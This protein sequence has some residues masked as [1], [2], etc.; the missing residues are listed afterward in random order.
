MQDVKMKVGWK[1]D[2]SQIDVERKFDESSTNVERMKVGRHR[3]DG[4]ITTRNAAMMATML[5]LLQFATMA[6]QCCC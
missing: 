1:S 5:L 3:C 4:D 2:E 6:L